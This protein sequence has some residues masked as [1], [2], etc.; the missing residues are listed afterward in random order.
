MRKS[1]VKE[2]DGWVCWWLSGGFEVGAVDREG[3]GEWANKY[4]GCVVVGG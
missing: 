1:C 3:E 4:D 2:L